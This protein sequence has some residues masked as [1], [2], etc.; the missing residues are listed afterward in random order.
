MRCVCPS[1]EARDHPGVSTPLSAAGRG[2]GCQSQARCSP[3]SLT[4]PKEEKKMSCKTPGA[5]TTRSAL[6]THVS[7]GQT[8]R[9]PGLCTSKRLLLLPPRTPAPL[10][11]QPRCQ[12]KPH[13]N[14]KHRS[15]QGASVPLCW[16]L[17]SGTGAKT[18][19]LLPPSTTFRD[20]TQPLPPLQ[21]PST[22]LPWGSHCKQGLIKPPTSPVL[23]QRLCPPRPGASVGP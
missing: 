19:S 10:G 17:K 11:S 8:P 2:G 13:R 20:I 16:H 7:Q 6:Q 3:G 15:L 1:H 18:S 14:G 5:G 22:P 23:G 9:L 12:H 4:I 21:P